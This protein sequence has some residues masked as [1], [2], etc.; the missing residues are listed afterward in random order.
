MSDTIKKSPAQATPAQTTHTRMLLL[1]KVLAFLIAVMAM[2]VFSTYYITPVYS[3]MTPWLMPLHRVTAFGFFLTAV[4]LFLQTSHVFLLR[5]IKNLLSL[6]IAGTALTSLILVLVQSLS[7]IRFDPL[8]L[9][10]PHSAISFIIVSV[11]LL[12][13]DYETEQKRHPAEYLAC[14]LLAINAIPLMGYFYDVAFFIQMAYAT[15]V[16]VLGSLLFMLVAITILMSRSSHSMMGIISQEAPGGQMLRRSLPQIIV[17]LVMLSL[18]VDYGE[19]TGVYGHALVAP[20]LTLLN[21]ILVLIVFWRVAGKLNDEYGARMTNAAKLTETTALLVTV[22]DNTDDLIFV[23]NRQGQMIFANPA[24]L[25]FIGKSREDAMNRTN[26]ELY[27]EPEEATAMDREEARIMAAGMPAITEQTLHVPRGVFTHQTT[28]APWFDKDANVM[29][30]VG[31][32][33]DITRRK[34]E[35]NSLRERELALEKTVIERTALLRELTNH[36]EI[37]REE[38]KHAIARE[39]HDNMGAALTALSM[40]LDTVYKIFPEDEKWGERKSR[41]Q[42]V[43]TSLVSTT[44]RIQT[45]LRPNM[46]DLFGLKAAITEQLDELAQR[47]GLTCTTS[48]PD[49]EVEIGPQMEIALYRMLQEILNNIVKHAQATT[50]RVILDVDED[51]VALTVKDNGVGMTAARKDNTKSYGLRGLR[52][53]AVYFGGTIDIV[54]SAEKG[55]VIA[56]ALPIMADSQTRPA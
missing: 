30:V 56:I 1:T 33:T 36:L 24:T 4:C 35:E 52:E 27:S 12:G 6:L 55:T 7:A 29:G 31:I 13:S 10:H 28:I 34:K 21:C 20:V 53:R 15:P 47:S 9:I 54:S 26:L 42:S 45:E 18:L 41:M 38:E 16:P 8:L 50:V 14:V 19:R 17:L 51:R 23:K 11:A 5:W 3:W 39:L 49:E 46:L 25:Q 37:V 22:S 43:L 2:T 40:H 32:S 48:L 44:R